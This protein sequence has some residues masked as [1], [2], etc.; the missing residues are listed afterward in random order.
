MQA[1]FLSQ[2]P[3]DVPVSIESLRSLASQR[4]RRGAGPRARRIKLDRV[5][6]GTRQR[7][8]TAGITSI[9]VS[10]RVD[11]IGPVRIDD[12]YRAPAATAETRIRAQR[13]GNLL[14]RGA[15]ECEASVLT[16]CGN[17]QRC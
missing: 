4:E 14:R 15:A 12:R 6:A 13:E 9:A 11:E 17:R 8:R 16:W 5:A 2:N 10:C 1:K 7:T 3:T